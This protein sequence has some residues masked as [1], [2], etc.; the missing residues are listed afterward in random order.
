MAMRDYICMRQ[1]TSVVVCDANGEPNYVDTIQ[2][3]TV[4]TFD[5][6]EQSEDWEQAGYRR[7]VENTGNEII[8]YLADWMECDI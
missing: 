4:L 8:L 2:E 7:A 1:F 5:L 6:K 3:N